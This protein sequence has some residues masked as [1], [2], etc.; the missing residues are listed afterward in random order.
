MGQEVNFNQV[1]YLIFGFITGSSVLLLPGLEAE[2]AAWIAVA[3]GTL[4]GMLLIAF[5]LKLS[6]INEGADIIGVSIM[7]LGPVLGRAVALG[8][9]WYF[10]HLGSLIVRDVTEFSTTV[11]FPQTPQVAIAIILLLLMVS[12]VRNGVEAM[13]K[14][15][16]V[17]VPVLLIFVFLLVTLLL[18]KVNLS[19]LKPWF[20]VDLK[21]FA[22]AVFSTVSF[23]FAEAVVL[24]V[25]FPFTQINKK[26]MVLAVGTVAFSGLILVLANTI[27]IS[28]L[29]AFAF[30]ATFPAFEAARNIE[31]LNFVE[32][33]EVMSSITFLIGAMIKLSVCLFGASVGLA[34]IFKLSSYQ[35]MVI[36][37]AVLIGNMSI[38]M[39]ENLYQLITWS[40]DIY[41]YYAL[42]FEILIPGLLFVISL[43][44]KKAKPA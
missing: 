43:M 5:Y 20:P 1:I 10:L 35:S 24:T 15:T 33:V 18:N 26:S 13:A 34:Q 30:N 17:V 39:Y 42:P 9:V 23:P 25:L 31:A 21:M 44:G 32:R 37:A 4:I 38:L 8:Y 40:I 12:L 6:S 29:G 36:P 14:F 28:T 41:P 27:T 7:R 19:N 11:S 2:N 22:K 16:Q 3:L